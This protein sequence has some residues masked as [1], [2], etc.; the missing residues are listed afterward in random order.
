[1]ASANVRPHQQEPAAPN[2]HRARLP[3]DD[4]DD[5]AASLSNS[6]PVEGIVNVLAPPQITRWQ[7]DANRLSDGLGIDE[8]IKVR[9]AR[10]PVAK[11]DETR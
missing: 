6:S 10:A 11:L 9:K 3:S 1:M 2:L 8:E 4:L 7:A 5:M